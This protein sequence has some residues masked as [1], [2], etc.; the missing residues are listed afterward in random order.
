MTPHDGVASFGKV[1][2]AIVEERPF[3]GLWS[4]YAMQYDSRALKF[5][6]FGFDAALMRRSSTDP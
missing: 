2:G 3:Q 1:R 6:S 4:C 5:K